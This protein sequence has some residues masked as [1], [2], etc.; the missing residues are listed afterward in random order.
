[1]FHLYTHPTHLPLFTLWGEPNRFG[2][3]ESY[4]EWQPTASHAANS[5]EA[6]PETA[7]QV[8]PAAPQR[9]ERG[10]NWAKS[11]RG[12]TG[13]F[14]LRSESASWLNEYVV[15]V[16]VVAIIGVVSHLDAVAE[17][18]GGCK[19]I[20]KKTDI[21]MVVYLPRGTCFIPHDSGL[22]EGGLWNWY[23]WKEDAICGGGAGNKWA[24]SNRAHYDSNAFP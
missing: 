23:R 17:M 16:V 10:S 7:R 1:M 21:C 24:S 14:S 4:S 12:R 18:R 8:M 2:P 11:F 5:A 6:V 9:K 15:A 13:L 20:R 19:R 22:E 3:T